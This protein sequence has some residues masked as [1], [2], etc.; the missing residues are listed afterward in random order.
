MPLSGDSLTQ[1]E[2]CAEI[3]ELLSLPVILLAMIG[4]SR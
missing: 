3:R 2:R 4:R 1:Y